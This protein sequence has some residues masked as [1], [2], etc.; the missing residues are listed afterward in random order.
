[1]KVTH[2]AK[3]LQYGQKMLWKFNQFVTIATT[4]AY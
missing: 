4:Q 1:M 2:D 3:S